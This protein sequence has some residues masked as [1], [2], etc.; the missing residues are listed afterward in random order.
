MSGLKAHHRK[1]IKRFASLEFKKIFDIKYTLKGEMDLNTTPLTVR[2]LITKY[3]HLSIRINPDNS[4]SFKEFNNSFNGIQIQDI[5]NFVNN[6]DKIRNHLTSL[7]KSLLGERIDNCKSP[8]KGKNKV[9]KRGWTR[10]KTLTIEEVFADL[11]EK[12][13]KGQTLH[14]RIQV[15]YKK[16]CNCIAEGC[17]KVGTHFA[18]EVDNGGGYHLDLF[19]EEGV[20]MT[21]DHHNPL[22]NGGTWDLENL[23]PMCEKCNSK[24]GSKIPEGIEKLEKSLAS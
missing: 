10:I 8:N 5:S 4:I 21:V 7:R 15:F 24:K 22:S 14:R 12:E 9:T 23:N 13:S 2:I 11:A 17:T 3:H 20:L 18:L 16:G 1:K 19:T 6:I